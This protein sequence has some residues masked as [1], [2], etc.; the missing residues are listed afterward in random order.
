MGERQNRLGGSCLAQVYRQLG[1]K[2]ANLDNPVR[3]K[4]LF[5]AVQFLNSK[6]MILAYHDISDGGLFVTVAEMCFAGHT[7]VTVRMDELGQNDLG[8]LFAEE[9]GAVIQVPAELEE[10]VLN[11]L[12]GHGLSNCSFVIGSLRDD[13][14]IVFTREG[15]D[16]INETRTHFRTAWAETTYHMQSLRD[17]PAC[18]KSEYDAKFD[19]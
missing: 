2:P 19:E 3:L 18:A 16:V 6:N 8:V 5:D 13:D 4:G 12:S 11:I 1:S 10:Q 14:R 15:Q 7:G 17:N 9:P